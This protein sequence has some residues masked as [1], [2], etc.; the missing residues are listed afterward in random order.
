[1]KHYIFTEF[2]NIVKSINDNQLNGLKIDESF[3]N[4]SDLYK[5]ALYYNNVNNNNLKNEIVD[6]VKQLQLFSEEQN[7]LVWFSIESNKKR[8][9][10]WFFILLASNQICLTYEQTKKLLK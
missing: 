9:V 6:T 5:S 8:S 4:I 10:K 7:E 2:Q 1:M 3:S